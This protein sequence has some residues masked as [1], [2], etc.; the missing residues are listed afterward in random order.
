MKLKKDVLQK[1]TNEI[2][3][4]CQAYDENPHASVEAMVTMAVAGKMGGCVGFRANS[5]EYVKAMRKAVG[6]EYVII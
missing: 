5:P 2:L 1:I 3:V 6:E 4:S